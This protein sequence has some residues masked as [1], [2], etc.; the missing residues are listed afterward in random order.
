VADT[1]AE[2]VTGLIL[3]GGAGRRM[4]GADKGLMT[5][6]GRTL[7]SHAIK[8]LAPQVSQLLISA[9]RN[10]D[11]YRTFG[12]PVLTD[13]LSDYQGPLVGLQAG[14]AACATPWLVICPCDCPAL[15][16]DLVERLRAAAESRNASIAVAATAGQMQPTFQLCRR[17]ILPALDEY[18]AGGGRKVAAWCHTQAA[19]EVD[20]P[21]SGAFDNLNTP[22]DLGN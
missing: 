14:L 10:L 20:F 18:L 4:G 5:Y 21:A 15:P 3:A 6:L 17:E 12:F 1:A 9:N 22:A 7:I 8:R 13:C 2:Q 16:L 11:V 19:V